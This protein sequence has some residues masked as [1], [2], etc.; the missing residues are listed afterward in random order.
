MLL[1]HVKEKV[2]TVAESHAES[3]S[4]NDDLTLNTSD[5]RP[6][7]RRAISYSLPIVP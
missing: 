2:D 7:R 4:I 6:T 5:M 3:S 1:G